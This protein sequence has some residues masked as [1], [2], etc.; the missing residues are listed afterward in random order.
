MSASN[1]LTLVLPGLLGP[2]PDGNSDLLFPKVPALQCLLSRSS[3]FSTDCSLTEFERLVFSL[4]DYAYSA[5]EELPVA[6]V[7]RLA[8]GF[9]ADGENY[10]RADPVQ[11]VADQDKV[12]LTASKELEVT[13][14]E[15][16]SLAEA[17]NSIYAEEGWSLDFSSP[18]CWYLR[19]GVKPEIK[20][21]SV[22]QAMGYAIQP[23]LPQG[24]KALQ[25]HA[26]MNEIQMLFHTHKVNIERDSRG[27]RL[28]TGLWLWGAGRLPRAAA[29]K[30]NRVWS[31][32]PLSKGLAMHASIDSDAVPEDIDAA[33][34][35]ENSIV[36]IDELL[37]PAVTGNNQLWFESLTRLEDELFNPLL[38][39]L[40]SGQLQTLEFYPVNGMRY[41]ISGKSLKRWWRPIKMLNRFI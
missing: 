2:F 41:R 11:L 3:R 29:G 20:T 25:W 39:A 33:I 30:F 1:N 16:R 24:N 32:E 12:Y 7:C 9:E 10:L 19:P 28:I 8:D 22:L 38:A 37:H 26:L 35:V 23:W 17:F 15:A 21:F 34:S 31:N 36:V 5:E 4:F 18:Q 27:A 13:E 6:A 40:E 14:K